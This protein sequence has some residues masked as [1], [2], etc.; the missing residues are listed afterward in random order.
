MFTKQLV[1]SPYSSSNG[2]KFSSDGYQR[3]EIQMSSSNLTN[4]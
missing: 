3:F 4:N 2:H 1:L